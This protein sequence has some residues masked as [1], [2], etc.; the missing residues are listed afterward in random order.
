MK[1]LGQN[2]GSIDRQLRKYEK[3]PVVNYNIVEYEKKGL[4]NFKQRSAV[5]TG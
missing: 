4:M 5:L 1:R 2:H 3:F